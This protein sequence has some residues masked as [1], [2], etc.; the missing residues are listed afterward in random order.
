MRDEITIIMLAFEDEIS[1]IIR[2]FNMKFHTRNPLK[3]W[4]NG[5]IEKNGYLD[6]SKETEYSLHG[7]GCTVEYNNGKLISFDFDEEDNFCYSPF[8]LMLYAQSMGENLS[9]SQIQSEF[10]NL[11]KEGKI[12]VLSGGI[13]LKPGA[14]PL[15]QLR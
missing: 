11:E 2:L 13:R 15:R 8:K 10:Q 7:A 3:I 14:L 9:E 4:R 1:E 12:E 6:F 5:L